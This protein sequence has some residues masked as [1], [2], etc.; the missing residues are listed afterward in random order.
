MFIIVVVH[1]L[2]SIVTTGTPSQLNLKEKSHF[3]FKVVY[4]LANRTNCITNALVIKSCKVIARAAVIAD[5]GCHY[6]V[7]SRATLNHGGVARSEERAL[8]SP[9]IVFF[10][11]ACQDARKHKENCDNKSRLE[12]ETTGY[13]LGSEGVVQSSVVCDLRLQGTQ[14]NPLVSCHQYYL[15]Q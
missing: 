14:M 7:L 12:Y 13:K 1:F 9:R 4:D 2:V 10:C 8:P 3:T 6:W 15:I 11:A 5:C